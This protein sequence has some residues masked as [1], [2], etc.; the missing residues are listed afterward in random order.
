MLHNENWKSYIQSSACAFRLVLNTAAILVSAAALAGAL[1]AQ[2]TS[3]AGADWA[4][5]HSDA[6]G[7]RYSALDQINTE[8][9]AQL[10]RAWV[11]HTNS[12][13]FASAPM[14]VDSFMYFSAP[15]GVYALDALTGEQVWKYPPDDAADEEEEVDA[16]EEPPAGARGGRGGRGG[17]G[18]RGSGGRGSSVGTALRGP[19][20]WPGTDEVGPR[21]YSS[22]SQGLAAIDATTGTL[23]TSF[24][25]DGFLPGV[26]PASF[27]VFYQGVLI[28]E[29]P[30][31][32]ENNRGKTVKAWDIVTGEPRW[33]FYTK[34]Q[35]G[36]PNRDATW[37]EGS[38]D[39]DAT[40][41]IW[42]MFTVDEERGTV[43]VPVEKVSGN[44]D[45]DYWGGGSPGD[46]LYADSLVALDALTGEVKWYYQMVHHDIWDYDIAAAPTLFDIE[47]D[48][49]VIP[50][51]AQ[52]D[53]MG[54]IFIF[55]RETGE[56]VFGVEERPVPQ[57]DISGE[58][59]SPTQPFP[60]KPPPLALNS[61]TRDQ[62]SKVTPE[63]QA[64]C[65]N[66]WD[67]YEL[68]DAV[69]YAPWKLEQDIVVLPGAQGGGNWH[70]LAFNKSLG[71]LIGTVLNAPQWGH[72]EIT[73]EGDS[74]RAR[75]VTPEQ[76]R[77]WDNSTQWS[78]T[79]PP[80]NELFA[81]DVNTGDVAWRVPLGEFEELTALGV[82]PT[83]VPSA[84]GAGITTAGNLVFIGATVDGYFRAFD[85]R[86]GKE[87][88]RDK[89]PQPNQG[90]PTTYLARDGKQYVVIG[91]NGGGYFGAPSGDEVIAYR[92]P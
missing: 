88:W 27:P 23:V 48:G 4:Y 12:G 52:F 15:N 31:E 64:F 17:F 7:T 66:L 22:M 89:L 24:G 39:T 60:L 63:H 30:V 5:P 86:N 67:K 25:E 68:E 40:P 29:G 71:L 26:R 73:G 8:N 55:N 50:A 1:L 19:I 61:L 11:F 85:A 37:L 13:R 20:F 10:E 36:D 38:A 65:E 9:V 28:A 59:T 62:L 58:W 34:A 49:E 91:A 77:F 76:R 3:K 14:V 47:R 69:P 90:T 42:G 70:G 87:L 18:G 74:Q 83:G 45:N 80:W 54:L 2:S 82:P 41:D 35:P 21:V 33:T 16:A 51:V 53:K 44:G 78:C 46:N 57:T 84:G 81:V 72:I 6:A 43:F 79:E 32:V 75:K 92:L 56:P